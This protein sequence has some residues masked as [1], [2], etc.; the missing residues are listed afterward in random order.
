MKSAGGSWVQ[1]QILQHADAD[2]NESTP[3]PMF[4]KKFINSGASNDIALTC[5][6]GEEEA[7]I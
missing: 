7:T 3:N 1:A 6:D 4:H 2:A 5:I